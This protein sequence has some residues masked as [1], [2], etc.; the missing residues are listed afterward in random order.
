M[1]KNKNYNKRSTANIVFSMLLTIVI[2][3]IFCLLLLT[4]IKLNIL[5]LKYLLLLTGVILLF[6]IISVILIWCRRIWKKVLGGVIAISIGI[7]SV[8]GIVNINK[9][10]GLLDDITTLIEEHELTYYI[11]VKNDTTYKT[12]DDLKGLKNGILD[13]NKDNVKKYFKSK[14]DYGVSK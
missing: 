9:T 8:F 4:L 3:L 11:L 1:R 14:V 12:L 13:N 6:D 2:F 7:I 5:P 10:Y